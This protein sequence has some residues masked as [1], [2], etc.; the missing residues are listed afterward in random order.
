MQSRIVDTE[1]WMEMVRGLLE[2]GKEVPV[3]VTGGSMSPF[4]VHGR[5]DVLVKK[6]EGN[7]GKGDILFYRRPSGQYVLHRV[8]KAAPD[9]SLFFA[10]DAQ[11]AVEGP[12]S[13]DCVFGCVERVRRK[14]KWI[15]KRDVRWRF[16]A[17]PWVVLLPLRRKIITFWATVR[18]NM[19]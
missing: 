17:G 18:H 10:G 11:T 6:G 2:E 19:L 16:F 4:L 7:Y 14:G 15:G 9:G 5:D 8:V 3:T 13:P 1:Q 12:V